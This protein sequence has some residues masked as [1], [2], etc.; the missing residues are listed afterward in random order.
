MIEKDERQVA[1][2]VDRLV[3]EERE[4][5]RVPS[6]YCITKQTVEPG[7]WEY[8]ERYIEKV[9]DP[10]SNDELIEPEQYAKII[11]FEKECK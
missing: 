3:M 5:N 10:L 1:A 6:V 7:T 2:A 9:N 11:E 8:W 4:R